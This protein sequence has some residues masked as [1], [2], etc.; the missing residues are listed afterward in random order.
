MES[1]NLKYEI[2]PF[3]PD[4]FNDLNVCGS[5]CT[6]A[7]SN[8]QKRYR[9]NDN[10]LIECGPNT[11]YGMIIFSPPLNAVYIPDQKPMYS[12]ASLNLDVLFMTMKSMNRDLN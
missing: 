12:I 3:L 1:N 11:N 5:R 7:S 9:W 2:P 4:E 8:V 10:Q 6:F